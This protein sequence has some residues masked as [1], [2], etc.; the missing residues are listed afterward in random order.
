MRLIDADRMKG[1]TLNWLL[2]TDGI[3][4]RYLHNE[5]DSQPSVIEGEV[6]KAEFVYQRTTKV[7]PLVI[8]YEVSPR[9]VKYICPI[10]EALGNRHQLTHGDKNC[11][12]CNVNL[13]WDGIE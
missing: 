10:C 2:E 12:L 1:N 8:V 11:T 5:L 3:R 7:K 9:Y 6:K 13:T 4:N